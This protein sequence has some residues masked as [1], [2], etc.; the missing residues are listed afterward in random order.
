MWQNFSLFDLR[1]RIQ[2]MGSGTP[3]GV[4]PVPWAQSLSRP[5]SGTVPRNGIRAYNPVAER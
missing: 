4:L 5:F 1:I 2:I 3:I